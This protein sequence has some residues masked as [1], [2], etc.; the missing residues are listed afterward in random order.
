MA[1]NTPTLLPR[2]LQ[3][4]GIRAEIEALFHQLRFLDDKMPYS[5]IHEFDGGV[6][7]YVVWSKDEPTQEEMESVLDYEFKES[8]GERLSCGPLQLNELAGSYDAILE[9]ARSKQLLQE[10]VVEQMQPR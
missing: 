8:Q 1:K 4:L 3:A 7:A 10:E 2:E 6:S 9:S 5:V